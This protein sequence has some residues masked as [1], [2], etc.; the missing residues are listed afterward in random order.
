MGDEDGDDKKIDEEYHLRLLN[1][2]KDRT[3][4]F[5]RS[6]SICIVFAILFFF[7]IL[8]SYT[9][10]QIDKTNVN[11]QI[12]KISSEISD[13]NNTLIKFEGIQQGYKIVEEKLKNF[14]NDFELFIDKINN[15]NID[16]NEYTHCKDNDVFDQKQCIANDKSDDAFNVILTIFDQ[17][18]TQPI[19]SLI[20]ETVFNQVVNNITSNQTNLDDNLKILLQ[21]KRSWYDKNEINQTRESV[22]NLLNQKMEENADQFWQTVQIRN[23]TYDVINGRIEQYISSTLSHS[24]YNRYQNDFNNVI[25]LKNDSKEQLEVYN[26]KL[27]QMEKDLSNT[28]QQLE[29]PIGKISIG[30]WEA[31]LIFPLL[32]T[33]GC[34]IVIYLVLNLFDLHMALFRYLKREFK[35]K[36]IINLFLPHVTP[37]WLDPIHSRITNIIR[38][39]VLLIPFGFFI[40]SCGLIFYDF[41]MMHALYEG[42]V[43]NRWTYVEIY[44]MCF[45]I[46]IYGYCSI[47]IK[48]SE[49]K[50]QLLLKS[51]MRKN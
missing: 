51:E 44:I 42:Q 18:I 11:K 15:S 46:I 45:G 23:N 43:I 22:K 10:I 2:Y 29:S 6:L 50:N 13:L 5:F 30:L 34:L 36:I 7:I 47:L 14:T 38:F 8:L 19:R 4:I 32:L 24:V 33:M 40:I 1:L 17:N 3:K 39:I 28:L 31:I 49:Y 16:L 26:N 9:T 37:S 20:G 35:N 27:N 12:V 21:T 25:T 48:F 41:A